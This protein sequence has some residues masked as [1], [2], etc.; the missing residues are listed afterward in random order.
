[1][2]GNGFDIVNCLELIVWE[3]GSY[4]HINKNK[5]SVVVPRP[6][7]FGSFERPIVIDYLNGAKLSHGSKLT[8]HSRAPAEIEDEWCTVVGKSSG[9]AFPSRV[10]HGCLFWWC[11]PVY[12]LISAKS[13]VGYCFS[14]QQACIKVCQ[15][16]TR[17][18]HL[19]QEKGNEQV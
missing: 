4:G 9:R 5:V 14:G 17:R 8:I 6:R 19:D 18:V 12:I 1:M 13:F 7:I 15:V 2:T 3:S 16:Y 11:I 10:K